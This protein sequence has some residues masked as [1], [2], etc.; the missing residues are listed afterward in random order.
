MEKEGEKTYQSLNEEK[1]P[2]LVFADST[3]SIYL[4]DMS[5]DGLTDLVRIRN[6]EVCYW[7]NTGYGHF[8][9]KITLDNSPWFDNL[10]QF[11]QRRIRIADIDGSGTTDIIY[12]GYH[13][14]DVYFN[15]S[16]NRLS[17]TQTL[18]TSF[19]H[20][21]QLSSVMVV[22]LLG[23]GT[24]CLV[25]SSPLP[26]DITRPMHYID[27]MVGQKPHLLTLIKNNMGAETS[28]K[29]APSTKFYLADKLEGRP[30]ITKIPFPVQVVE[31]VET[32]DRISRNLFVTRYAY[33]HGYFDGIEREFRGFGMVEQFDTEEFAALNADDTLPS[34]SNVEEPSHVPPVKTKTWFH[35]GAYLLSDYISLH[36]R[37][38]YYGAPKK[39]DIDYVNKFKAFE[40][41]LLDD[42]V[43][44][45]E[46]DEFPAINAMVTPDE[47]REACRALKGSIL[48]QE[49]YALDGLPK[50]SEHP[51]SVSERN[52]T[53]KRIQPQINNN[54]HAVFFIHSRETLDYHYERNPE[55]PRLSHTLTLKVD[56]YGNV[57]RSA[58]IGYGRFSSNQDS[59]LSSQDQIK[60]SQLLIT[61]TENIFTNSIVSIKPDHTDGDIYRTS[62]PCE[63]SNYELTGLNPLSNNKRFDFA[64]VDNA[65]TNA[66]QIEYQDKPSSP[67]MGLQKR[68]INHSCILYRKDNL[69]GSLP[70]GK[71]EPLGLV[72]ETYKQAFTPG[73]V[74]QVYGSRV[75]DTMLL[76]E[77][78]YVHFKSGLSQNEDS[79]WWIPSGRLLY[80]PNEDDN[81]GDELNFAKDHFFLP[82]R[83]R[84]PFHNNATGTNLKDGKITYDEYALLIQQTRDPLDNVIAAVT[85]DTMD[86]VI[87]TLDYRV[88]QP[89]MVTDPNDN[90][91]EVAY[92]I[93]GLVVGTAVMGKVGE[94]KG[95]SLEGF[96]SIL[97]DATILSHI[98]NPFA[99]NPQD[100]LK[101]LQLV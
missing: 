46:E 29:Y 10:D 97:D 36:Y 26:G 56:K 57:I 25:W 99:S 7:P 9:V 4:A 92:D 40:N 67:T 86:R 24:A 12:L 79:N 88:L 94:I 95:D 18:N 49:I 64:T 78:R 13:G 5:G 2:R 11:D 63:S 68:L 89:W 47:E 82:H 65:I 98:Q 21:D 93:L 42:T 37:D 23:N 62:L 77:G 28:I 76:N 14:I 81:P 84:D 16:G 30:W 39:G 75:T 17:E 90:R 22:D 52:Y 6:G 50:K 19:P 20:I 27:L 54:L 91:D 55:D 32:Y 34:S 51:Y 69:D 45:P 48:R 38:E 58:S 73:L 87:I 1:G 3:Q 41:T 60:Q 59:S 80:S 33:H 31:K 43:L 44:P 71:I 96:E 74:S 83:F 85:K 100:I 101:K 15:Q 61:C 70:L 53:I 35:T 8:G 72:Y 66:V